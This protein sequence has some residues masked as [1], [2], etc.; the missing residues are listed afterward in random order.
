MR[1]GKAALTILAVFLH[2]MAFAADTSDAETSESK[3]VT[4]YAPDDLEVHANETVEF[5]VQIYN[6]KTDTLHVSLSAEQLGFLLRRACLELLPKGQ[7]LGA[8]SV[9]EKADGPQLG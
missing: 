7:R 1:Y 8:A 6:V 2:A 4:W 5:T 3:N 9:L